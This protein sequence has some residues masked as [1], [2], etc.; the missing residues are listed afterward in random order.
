[1]IGKVKVLCAYQGIPVPTNGRPALPIDVDEVLELLSDDD[2]YW[3]E[4]GPLH[5]LLIGDACQFFIL[6]ESV[7]VF[8]LEALLTFLCFEFFEQ[9]L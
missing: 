9:L 1:V 7:P 5:N 4:V 2:S 3:W 6:E 8:I